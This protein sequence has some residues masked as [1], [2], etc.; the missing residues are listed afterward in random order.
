MCVCVCARFA[1]VAWIYQS[2][3][4]KDRYRIIV[5]RLFRERDRRERERE[6]NVERF[7]S[8]LI[9]VIVAERNGIIRKLHDRCTTWRD[10]RRISRP[11]DT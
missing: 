7:I 5:D 11:W 10:F 4:L 9:S 3:N 2:W 8:R 1:S 6:K